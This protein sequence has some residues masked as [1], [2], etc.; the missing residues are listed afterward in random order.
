MTPYSVTFRGGTAFGAVTSKNVGSI[1]GAV[2]AAP[3]SVIV[4]G[5]APAATTAAAVPVVTAV[6]VRG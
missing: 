6:V 2:T 1:V 5:L 4:A 3:A